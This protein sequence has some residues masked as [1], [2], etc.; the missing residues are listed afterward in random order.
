MTDNARVGEDGKKRFFR[1]QRISVSN[2]KFYFST[3]EGTLEGPFDTREEAEREL[4]MFIRQAT[5]KDIYG[6]IIRDQ[7]KK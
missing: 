3:R 1:S 5:G 4:A 2:G 7:P 6:S